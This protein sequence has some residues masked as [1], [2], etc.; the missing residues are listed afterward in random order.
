MYRGYRFLNGFG[1]RNSE[2][3]VQT[4]DLSDVALILEFFRDTKLDFWDLQRFYMKY[5]KKQA[6][7][8][9]NSFQGLPIL[10]EVDVEG[11]K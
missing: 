8:L 1:I 6:L 4:R 3:S 10:T 9:L 7:G 11:R 5:P 2:I